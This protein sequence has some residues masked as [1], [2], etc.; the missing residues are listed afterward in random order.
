[1][2]LGFLNGFDVDLQLW[3]QLKSDADS[4]YSSASEL[5]KHSEGAEEAAAAAEAKLD[6]AKK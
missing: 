4:A 6:T 2:H 3:E 5:I 1:L